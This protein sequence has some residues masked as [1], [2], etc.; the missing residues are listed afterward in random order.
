MKF[1]NTSATALAKS[2][3]NNLQILMDELAPT[4][5]KTVTVRQNNPWFDDSIKEQ[6][7]RM[8]RRERIWLR[9]KDTHQWKAYCVE[10]NKL[11]FMIRKKKN[12]DISD[13]IVQ[14]EGDSKVLYGLLRSITG[15]KTENPM[16][17][18]KPEVLAEEF[19]DA[20]MNKI[21]KIRDNLKDIPAYSPEPIEIP[22]M[23]FREMKPKEIKE[24]ILS[25]PTKSCESDVINT[26][27]L[28]RLLSSI[29]PWI[30]EIVNMSLASGEFVSH[31][32]TAIIRPLLK[33]I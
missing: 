27:L 15:T 8:R 23:K 28:K 25:M 20:F 5:E 18:H 4:V 29:L 21:Y 17:N 26:K 12:K 11:N 30:V 2:L 6:R 19:A 9:Y 16:P 13:K 24:I 22:D 31:W 33:K 10:R 3:E 32:K 1:D 7:A 14:N